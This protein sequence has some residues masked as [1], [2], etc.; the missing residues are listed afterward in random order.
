MSTDWFARSS[1]VLRASL[2]SP[3]AA[4]GL[5]RCRRAVDL[6]IAATAVA[7]GLPLYTAIRTDL[8]GLSDVPEIVA[9]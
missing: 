1:P 2:R 7:S 3:E 4:P 6:P 8:A 5:A 9:V